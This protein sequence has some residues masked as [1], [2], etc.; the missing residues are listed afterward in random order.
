[1]EVGL[2]KERGKF[3]LWLWDMGRF[4]LDS[5]FDGWLMFD[6]LRHMTF[7]DVTSNAVKLLSV[8]VQDDCGDY[9]EMRDSSEYPCAISDTLLNGAYDVEF[10]VKS[11][12][13]ADDV[14]C[15]IRMFLS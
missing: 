15:T 8:E 3:F 11:L 12:K 1:M 14:Q 2:D 13:C 7:F 10:G 5:H 6:G 4:F 9:S